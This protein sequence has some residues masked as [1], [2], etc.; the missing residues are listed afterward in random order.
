MPGGVGGAAPRGVPYPDRWHQ[1]EDLGSAKSL[2]SYLK[3]KR[4]AGRLDAMPACDPN[5]VSCWVHQSQCNNRLT[6]PSEN[7]SQG[8]RT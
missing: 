6:A 7:K 2:G 8:C 1:A 5:P 4:L 3:N